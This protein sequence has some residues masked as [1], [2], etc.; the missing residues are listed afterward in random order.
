ME[1]M[2]SPLSKLAGGRYL[3]MHESKWEGMKRARFLADH[4]PS[5][6]RADW[7]VTDES[8][9]T[10][11]E[12]K[13]EE[14]LVFRRI[15]PT[16]RDP[17]GSEWFLYVKLKEYLQTFT[18]EMVQMLEDDA[19]KHLT[20]EAIYEVV[21]KGKGWH[22]IWTIKNNR[23]QEVQVSRKDFKPIIGVKV[24]KL[25]NLKVENDPTEWIPFYEYDDA[26]EDEQKNAG[27]T[28]YLT[29]S[30]L[31]W[32]EATAK[33]T[34]RRATKAEEGRLERAASLRAILT[35]DST[36][37]PRY[38]IIRPLVKSELSVA[39]DYTQTMKVRWD[40]F[41][42]MF[43]NWAYGN[44]PETIDKHERIDPLIDAQLLRTKPEFSQLQAQRFL[45]LLEMHGPAIDAVDMNEVLEKADE[46]QRAQ[47]LGKL[48]EIK[49]FMNADA[50][51][52]DQVK[53]AYRKWKTSSMK[54]NAFKGA[55][56]FF[57]PKARVWLQM[58]WRDQMQFMDYW[59]L[60]IPCH[61]MVQPWKYTTSVCHGR[62]L[63]HFATGYKLSFP[64]TKDGMNERVKAIKQAAKYTGMLLDAAA[65]IG[66]GMAWTS[67]EAAIG[68]KGKGL[69]DKIG[70]TVSKYVEVFNR[71]EGDSWNEMINKEI[72]FWDKEKVLEDFHA[73]AAK[74]NGEG[75][76]SYLWHELQTLKPIPG[77]PKYNAFKDLLKQDRF[78]DIWGNAAN[79]RP[80]WKAHLFT[81]LDARTGERF[82]VC[83][84]HQQ[85]SA[86]DVNSNFVSR[87]PIDSAYKV[88]NHKQRDLYYSN[89]GKFRKD[90]QL[91]KGVK[92]A[93]AKKRAIVDKKDTSSKAEL[94]NGKTLLE[95]QISKFQER[96][97]LRKLSALSGEGLGPIPKGEWGGGL[98]KVKSNQGKSP[99]DV[100]GPWKIQIIS[101]HLDSA[102]VRLSL[103]HAKKLL[104]NPVSDGYLS[105]VP[106][107][108]KI[109]AD[110]SFCDG[111]WHFNDGTAKNSQ[112]ECAKVKK[113]LS[114]RQ[115]PR[116]ICTKLPFVWTPRFMGNVVKRGH[117]HTVSCQEFHLYI[118]GS[119]ET[120]ERYSWSGGL[121]EIGMPSNI[122]KVVGFATTMHKKEEIQLLQF[123]TKDG[124]WGWVRKDGWTRMDCD[125][126]A[127]P[128]KSFETKDIE[129][130]ARLLPM[131]I[132]GVPKF[133]VVGG[134]GEV[135]EGE[136]EAAKVNFDWRLN[137]TDETEFLVTGQVQFRPVDGHLLFTRPENLHHLQRIIKV[138]HP[139]YERSFE[140]YDE[141]MQELGD[142][143]QN[144]K[145]VL[146]FDLDSWGTYGKLLENLSSGVR[147]KVGPH[148]LVKTLL[149]KKPD[150][151]NG[152]KK[153][154]EKI[155]S[156]K[157]FQREFNPR[158]VG[159][160]TL[161]SPD[162]INTTHEDATKA[163]V[164][165]AEKGE[166]TAKT[167]MDSDA[168]LKE[169]IKETYHVP[170]APTDEE[171]L[172]TYRDGWKAH[173][174]EKL[175][176]EEK[177][178]EQKLEA[179]FSVLGASISS[180]GMVYENESTDLKVGEVV[181][182]IT[183]DGIRASRHEVN[184]IINTIQPFVKIEF[185]VEP[186]NMNGRKKAIHRQVILDQ[187]DPLLLAVGDEDMRGA[188]AP[189]HT[190]D[191]RKVDGVGIR[192]PPHVRLA[193]LFKQ[194]SNSDQIITV[195]AGERPA[196][197]DSG[198][199]EFNFT[200]K[201]VRKNAQFSRWP[202]S[203]AFDYAGV[204]N[205]T[206]EIPPKPQ[207]YTD[208]ALR[209]HKAGLIMS[210]YQNKPV[211]GRPQYTLSGF[212]ELSLVKQDPTESPISFGKATDAITE[213]E[214]TNAITEVENTNVYKYAYPPIAAE[215]H[216]THGGWNDLATSGAKFLPV[217]VDQSQQELL[218]MKI[219]R[220]GGPDNSKRKGASFAGET[221]SKWIMYPKEGFTKGFYSQLAMRDSGKLKRHLGTVEKTASALWSGDVI[222]AVNGTTLKSWFAN[223][224]KRLGV[225]AIIA[226]FKELLRWETTKKPNN[227]ALFGLGG[228]DK[229]IH[230]ITFERQEDATP[231]YNGETLFES[232]RPGH[233]E[234]Q[235]GWTRSQRLA[236]SVH[237]IHTDGRH[238]I[239]ML[240]KANRKV[241]DLMEK[242]VKGSATKMHDWN[243]HRLDKKEG[244]GGV[245]IDGD[246][247]V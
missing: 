238:P 177:E 228:E 31:E 139:E 39:V 145:L 45:E 220:F 56:H 100:F 29:R 154:E 105:I 205:R 225:D 59:A 169:W 243:Q 135:L 168:N 183:P 123:K 75:H 15:E 81:L 76:L 130:N 140:S 193:K 147:P 179:A 111:Y 161:F 152:S 72:D 79:T 22:L 223:S 37:V 115:T 239:S 95:F 11:P 190:I 204:Q 208:S 166:E 62:H 182:V 167:T 200:A 144:S 213:V 48:D 237:R 2:F 82:H 175:A 30:R 212:E 245:H 209:S 116:L 173:L 63:Q 113:L 16:E 165:L 203:D 184:E 112:E 247:V 114:T 246:D 9:N 236:Q 150:L 54:D 231:Q 219:L 131:D 143:V 17:D 21:Q 87:V 74:H 201:I 197:K 235:K 192:N 58:F 141:M 124:M 93:A 64:H 3:E 160:P 109:S 128:K 187:L 70:E 40:N 89:I 232:N 122:L 84:N 52:S 32:E 234:R 65:V 26:S 80:E 33:D 129:R 43:T 47:L 158:K 46:D 226:E 233:D 120:C 60:H 127:N 172:D 18:Q 148:R 77:G 178:M 34:F 12:T 171:K 157:D 7:Q 134:N 51:R 199:E 163:Y 4:Q 19:S 106:R 155:S 42:R 50:A 119:P 27:Y 210:R 86:W 110:A 1:K 97:E 198:L 117:T 191:G 136:Y 53:D 196:D 83:K 164:A 221:N 156:F 229:S 28:V 189:G 138:A 206:S 244:S 218:G 108:M 104:Q 66:T 71:G 142:T 6:I 146:T 241:G 25:V 96:E 91:R 151:G 240:L 149:T 230:T 195:I 176:V 132:G 174:K 170:E 153:W 202:T 126:I 186:N 101:P 68:T 41:G 216:N 121:K 90:Q 94:F 99:N 180:S 49:A 118:H 162:A 55:Q 14:I 159:D 13:G 20:R 215:E 10:T 133:V 181:H 211:G 214:N 36:P 78:K 92:Q 224:R 85:P 194:L 217:W 103:L 125:L 98:V 44:A 73:F 88:Q 67:A 8:I 57:S 207:R 185:W 222:L 35:Q 188:L 242:G 38:A 61:A 23:G 69:M 107:D 102:R 227:G 24:S 137:H 5:T